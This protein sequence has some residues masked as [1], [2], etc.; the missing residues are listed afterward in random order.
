MSLEPRFDFARN[1]GAVEDRL[2]AMVC[3]QFAG[4][5]RAAGIQHVVHMGMRGSSMRT[6][7]AAPAR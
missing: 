1:A 7:L 3:D 5:A 6:G 2:E 4:D